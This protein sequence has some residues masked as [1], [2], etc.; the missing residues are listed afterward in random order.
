MSDHTIRY[1]EPS[2]GTAIVVAEQAQRTDGGNDLLGL[3][4][5]DPQLGRRSAGTQCFAPVRRAG[6]QA[7]HRT[8]TARVDAAP[9]T[10]DCVCGNTL[11]FTSQRQPRQ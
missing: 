6:C 9:K 10:R 5:R 4:I 1:I 8:R 11:G 7:S 3:L 2:V